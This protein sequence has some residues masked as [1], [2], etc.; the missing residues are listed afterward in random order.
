M[1]FGRVVILYDVLVLVTLA[2]D[3]AI[4]R[5]ASA[6]VGAKAPAIVIAIAGVGGLLA[7]SERRIEFAALA[8]TV[9][10]TALFGYANFLA[11]VKRGIT[12]SIIDNHARPQHE[13]RPDRDFVALAERL[14]EMRG[15]GW[16][17]G[18]GAG[19]RRLNARGQ[20]VVRIRRALL[21]GLGIEA[22]G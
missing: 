3:F 15:Y 1:T 5:R 4:V 22:V 16:I 2:L 17:D 14:D 21:R 10:L 18:E 19:T 7:V 11:F 6:S 8:I 13:R 20:R 12:F 9:M